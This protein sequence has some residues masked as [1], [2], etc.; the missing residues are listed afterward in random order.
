MRTLVVA[1]LLT[2]TS[3]SPAFAADINAVS[4]IDAVT[5]FPQGAEVTRIAEARISAGEHTLIFDGLPGDL[6]PETLRIEGTAKGVIEIGSVDSKAVSLPRAELDAD[7]RRIEK[8]IETLADERAAL[9]QV[10][11]DAE[12]EKSLMQQLAAGTLTRKPEEGDTRILN[13][14][15]LSGVLDL[16][17]TRLASLG[18]TSLD[19]RQRQREIDRLTEDLQ[20]KLAELAPRGGQRTRVTVHLSAPA[21]TEGTFKLRYRVWYAGWQPIYDARLGAM[22]K[23]GKA[24]IELV[25][26]AEVSQSTAESWDNIAL[27]LSTARPLGE[28]A[29]P[30]L[31]PVAIDKLVEARRESYSIK[32]K[33]DERIGPE[34]APSELRKEEQIADVGFSDVESPL[35]A[36]LRQ[37]QAN[38]NIA[39]FQA[40]YAIKDR[41]SI[42][43]AGT[44]KKV[45]IGTDEIDAKLSALA[46]PKLDPNAYLTAAFTLAGDTPLLPG[47][48]LLYREGVFMGQGVFPL[49]S[50]GE[51][52]KLGFGADDLIKVKRIEVKRR[53]AEEGL[54]TTSNVDERAFDI[55]VKNLH[56]ASIPVTILDQAPYST[57]Q[58]IT[59]ETLSGMT[60][61]T[62]KDYERQ[63]GILAWSFDLASQDSKVIKH[64]YKI[65]WPRDVKLGS[66]GD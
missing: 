15:G 38:V 53:T 51:E 5:V 3:L 9:D 66:N 28:T 7:R 48:I 49:L 30:D 60:P 44:A 41:V 2:T 35:D 54:L 62:V 11:Q 61:A 64:G 34:Q 19:V 13:A 46:V 32:T 21:Q 65:S 16:V 45:R 58:K 31:E 36:A 59:V 14:Q 33:D 10:I 55:T 26:R 47:L 8:D 20:K 29:A 42:D 17:S 12:Y 56:Q 24:R 18:K 52:T 23:D 6:S 40:L 37:A 63:R 50:P 43:N 57:E 22:D 1:L 27:T 4:R 39:G 25:R